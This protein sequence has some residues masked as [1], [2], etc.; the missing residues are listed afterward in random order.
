VHFVDGDPEADRKAEDALRQIATSIGFRHVSFEFEP[1]AAALDYERSITSEQ[2]A[3]IADI[4]GGTSDFSVV[5]IGP[6]GSRGGDRQ[7][8]ILANDGV[9]VGGTDFD[10]LLSL[11]TVMPELGFRSPA[12]RAG[13][14]VPVSYFHDLA[15]WSSINR[16]YAPKVRREIEEVRREAARPQ[17]IDRLLTVLSLEK[18][19]ALAMEVERVKIILSEVLEASVPLSWIEPGLGVPI[20]RP[21]L[22]AATSALTDR[23]H[24]TVLRCVRDAGI[25]PEDVEVLFLTG[26]STRVRHARAAITAAVPSARVVE[27]DT[28]GSVGLGL[29]IEASRRYGADAPRAMAV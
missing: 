6:L 27:G 7:R 15:T 20:D 18:G 4:G 28:F 8:D 3:L 12:K 22:V 21:A 14:D 29:T 10:R 24:A 1:I 23:L 5:R 13:L 16:L 26:G 25:A 2:I 9:R 19:H 11:N 17:L